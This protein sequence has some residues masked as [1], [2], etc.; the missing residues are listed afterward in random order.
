MDREAAKAGEKLRKTGKVPYILRHPPSQ[1]FLH[2]LQ[3]GKARGICVWGRN[4]AA[5][6]ANTGNY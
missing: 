2:M 1:V 5:T 6:A 4:P 3:H